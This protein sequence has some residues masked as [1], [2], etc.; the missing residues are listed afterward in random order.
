MMKG[1]GEEVCPHLQG[2]LG[3]KLISEELLEKKHLDFQRAQV[4]SEMNTVIC[5][6]SPPRYDNFLQNQMSLLNCTL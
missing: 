4:K 3:A 1:G 2:I 6:F 5:G